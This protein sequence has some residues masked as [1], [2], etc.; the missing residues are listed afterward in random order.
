MIWDGMKK[1][2]IIILV[3]GSVMLLLSRKTYAMQNSN[4]FIDTVKDNMNNIRDIFIG[5]KW[6]DVSNMPENAQ[7][8]RWL[9]DAEVKYG[10]PEKMLVAIAWQES[11][12]RPDIISGQTKSGAGAAGIM[13]IVP[14]WHPGI[15]PL[16]PAAAIDYAGKYLRAMYQ[17]FGSWERALWA[18]NWGPGNLIKYLDGDIYDMPSETEQYSKQ[19]LT[20]IEHAGTVI[21]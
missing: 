21:T 13:Q 15:N 9:T 5:D 6:L 18:Y 19:I 14:K 7:Y 2:H 20:H 12:F 17:Q 10:I 1:E 11:R 8:L 3:L 16:D 4:D